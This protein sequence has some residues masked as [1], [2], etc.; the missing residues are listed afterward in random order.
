MTSFRD[1]FG[2]DMVQVRVGSDKAICKLH[3][4]I[5]CNVAPYFA[6]AF[7]GGFV[8]AREQVLELPDENS[9][10]FNRFQLWV[11]TRHLLAEGETDTDISWGLLV[12]LYI[13]GEKCGVPD[14]QNAAIDV[15][16]RKQSSANEIPTYLLLRVYANTLEGS[17]LRRLFVD[18]T[19]C[20]AT[21]TPNDRYTPKPPGAPDQWFKEET[22]TE[23]P[24]DFLFD[25]AFAQFQLRVGNTVIIT[26]FW[27]KRADYYVKPRA[28]TPIPPVSGQK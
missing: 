7:K 2:I 22:R 16:I 23:Y 27:P 12:G 20:L 11:Y 26:N 25:L 3:K 1:S 17:S 4:K 10:M 15:L 19:A 13:F 8:E 21:M 9:A 14:L 28:A 5:L 18:W 24:K 6:A